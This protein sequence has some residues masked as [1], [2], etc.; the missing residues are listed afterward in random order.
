[1][2]AHIKQPLLVT[3]H[4]RSEDEGSMFCRNI[5]IEPTHYTARKAIS[6]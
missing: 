4:L 3:P 6:S 1:M 5:D 2:V